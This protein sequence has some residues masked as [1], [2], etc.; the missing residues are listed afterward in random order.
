MFCNCSIKVTALNS[1]IK[2][3]ENLTVWKINV[4]QG[5]RGTLFILPISKDSDEFFMNQ[6]QE[7]PID[8]KIVANFISL[9]YDMQED[10]YLVENL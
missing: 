5:I 7:M 3:R 4:Q 8:V 6:E 9:S 2:F 1:N 10:K